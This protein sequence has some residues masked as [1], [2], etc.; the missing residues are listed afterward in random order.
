MGCYKK[1]KNGDLISWPCG[2]KGDG[3]VFGSNFGSG[4]NRARNYEENP[5]DRKKRKQRTKENKKNAKDTKK[6]YKK[7]DKHYKKNPDAPR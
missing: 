4:A 5:A 1:T 3:H 6:H 2:K 7:L